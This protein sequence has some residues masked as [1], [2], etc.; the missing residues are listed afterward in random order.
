MKPWQY[1][2]IFVL[3]LAVVFAAMGWVSVTTLRLDRSQA[4]AGQKA[5][6]E[7]NVRLA[8]WRME[9]ALAP[10]LARESSRPY[11]VYSS[12]YPPERAYTKMYRE[13]DNWEIM[14]PSPLLTEENPR[15]IL[16]FQF[17]PDGRLSSPQV[18]EGKMK[19]LSLSAYDNGAMIDTTDKELQALKACLSAK[20]LLAAL[21]ENSRADPARRAVYLGNADNRVVGNASGNMDN[22]TWAANQPMQ[23]NAAPQPGGQ[24]GLW[25]DQQEAKNLNEYNV[26]NQQQMDVRTNV[27][28]RFQKPAWPQ[29]TKGG[30]Q[31]KE[32]VAGD[33]REGILKPLWINGALILA[34][35]VTVDGRDYVQGCRLNWPAIRSE[36]LAQI[37]DLLKEADLEPVRTDASG[38]EG[39]VLAGLPVRLL[40]GSMPAGTPPGGLTPV[41]VSLIIAWSCVLLAGGAVG[42]LLAGAVTLSERRG[43]FVSAV[44]HELRTPLTTFRMYAE[45]LSE[46]MVTDEG[47]KRHYLATLCAEGS[48]LSH[49]VENVLSYARLERGRAAG[50]VETLAVADVL[51]RTMERLSQRAEQAGMKLIMGGEN[52]AAED[53]ILRVRVRT[54]LSAL[55]QILF[56]LVDNACKYAA[57]ADDKRIHIEPAP[58]GRFVAIRVRDHGPGISE[59]DARKLFRPFSKSAKHAAE[60]APG[61]G[62]GLALSR[63][64]ARQMGGDLRIAS[65]ASG[66]A[67]FELTLPQV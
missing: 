34:R 3:C 4:E 53:S 12:F 17:D 61:V 20:A 38:H 25:P 57:Q 47:K 65:A 60:S 50:R 1:W 29:G 44:T 43:A 24:Q 10:L 26:R 31:G 22:N 2:L 63:R 21:P 48:R 49:L 41:Q 7:E 67:C 18:P 66:G 13:V 33:V 52:G 64:L 30:K 15:V 9:S 51:D 23:Q 14:V 35:R 39:R 19:K 40:P 11:F 46:G 36:L 8:L 6:F 56:N 62:L 59:A 27:I 32:A 54:D 55:E 37:K 42:I 5:A 45:M 28:G 16:H 58:A